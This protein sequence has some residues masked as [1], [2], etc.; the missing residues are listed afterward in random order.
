MNN[1]ALFFIGILLSLVIGLGIWLNRQSANQPLSQQ[2]AESVT[3]QLATSQNNYTSQP[4]IQQQYQANQQVEAEH[5]IWQESLKA[6]E[7][8]QA[9]PEKL[10][11]DL[12]GEAYVE[13]STAKIKSMVMGDQFEVAIPQ[14]GGSL[15]AEV[16]YITE[17]PNGDKTVEAFF[18]GMD[19]YFSVVFTVG[20]AQTYA[21]ISTPDGVYILEG[22]GDYAWIA[23]RQSL[24]ASHYS[25]H[26]DGVLPPTDSN[27]AAA[28]NNDDIDVDFD[29]VVPES[30]RDDN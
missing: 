21:Q 28:E 16:D 2:D 19:R 26:E 20:A 27:G 11:G 8:L 17:H 25:G 18:P 22:Q 10:P 7:I 14:L 4:H 12:A 13:L 24:V 9:N 6:Q 23:S 1:K 30:S 5:I 3:S 15:A 29:Y